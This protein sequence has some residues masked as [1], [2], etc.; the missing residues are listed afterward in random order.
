MKS[1]ILVVEDDDDLRDLLCTAL[2]GPERTL[3]E[4]EHGLAALA[5]IEAHGLPDLILLDMN[6][7]IMHGWAFAE[8]MRA[9]D[10]WRVP[11]IVIT[12]ADD[13]ARSAQEIGAAGH[14]RKPFSVHAL[15]TLVETHIP[16]RLRIERSI[17]EH[18]S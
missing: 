8:A 17:H 6:M 18:L 2:S 1:T 12:A 11:V 9:R 14:L 16:P 3:L 10:L 5:L 4:A 7:P 15:A 13:A